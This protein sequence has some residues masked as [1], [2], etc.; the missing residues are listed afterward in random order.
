MDHEFRKNR[1]ENLAL[2]RKVLGAGHKSPLQKRPAAPCLRYRGRVIGYQSVDTPEPKGVRILEAHHCT[3]W[4]PLLTSYTII[5]EPRLLEY[6]LLSR[7][8]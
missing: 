2:R 7:V 1:V 4:F 6:Q 3:F 8:G 5:S